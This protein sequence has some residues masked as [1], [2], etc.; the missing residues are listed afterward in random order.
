[1]RDIKSVEA[2]RTGT[3]NGDAYTEDDLDA[4]VTA[5]TEVGF[6]PPLTVGHQHAPGAPAI[7]W[8]ENLR[9]HGA[10][11]LADL[12]ALPD[13]IFAQVRDRAFDRLSAEIYWDFERAGRVYS[14][15][16][17]AVALLGAETPAVDL[18]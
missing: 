7:G 5:S 18:K 10:V 15:V 6:T 16:L 12:V 13:K 11:L 2:F 9:R 14:R 4:M 8:V 1:M 3:W 17:K